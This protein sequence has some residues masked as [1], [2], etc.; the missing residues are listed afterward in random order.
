VV[1][2]GSLRVYAHVWPS[3]MKTSC[4]E[5]SFCDAGRA[6]DADTFLDE[7]SWLRR[8]QEGDQEAAQALIR[9]L[10]P[11]IIRSVR[12]HLPR[13][14]SEEDLVQAVFAKLFKHLNQFSGSVPLE[15]WVSRITVN[16]CLSQLSREKRRRELRMSDLSEEEEAVVQDLLRSDEELELHRTRDAQAV[17]EKLLASL[18]PEER[19]VITL[20]HLEERS[21]EEI[22]QLLGW[23]ISRV[24]VKAFRARNKMRRLW[25]MLVRGCDAVECGWSF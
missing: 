13:S 19:L 16:T 8:V 24:K 11:T 12:S 17:L 2:G 15:H 14:S 5:T 9:R 7:V 25:S 22:S 4:Q 23:S 20:L 10:Y 18:R 6:A 1:S 21:I 3:A